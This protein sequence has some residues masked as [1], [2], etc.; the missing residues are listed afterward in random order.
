[1]DS[2]DLKIVRLLAEDGR[3][4]YREI[5][6]KL[7]ISEPTARLRVKQLIKTRKISVK[8]S[9]NIDEFPEIIIAYVG[10][11]HTG[12]IMDCFDI[13][14]SIPEVVH[15]VNTIGRYDLIAVMAVASRE[16]LA[17]ILTNEIFGER[18]NRDK[19]FASTETHVV[20]YNRNLFLPANK[21]IGTLEDLGSR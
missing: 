7:D 15:T 12:S 3:I 17:D 1:M 5:A 16:R 2:L 20:L 19:L 4:S 18:N 8:A 13:L 11:K 6:R 14:S 10:I 21:V 9:V